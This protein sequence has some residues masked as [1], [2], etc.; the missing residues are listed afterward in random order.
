MLPR[1]STKL[2]SVRCGRCVQHDKTSYKIGPEIRL[3]KA[4]CVCKSP[5]INIHIEDNVFSLMSYRL[6]GGC[7][8]V[9]R[10]HQPSKQL[11]FFLFSSILLHNPLPNPTTQKK[12]TELL[13]NSAHSYTL[14]CQSLLQLKEWMETSFRLLSNT[15]VSCCSLMSLKSSRTLSFIKTRLFFFV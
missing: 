15:V 13:C 5:S 6:C 14:C 1:N 11:F 4:K 3:I 12:Q 8:V 9:T 7:S 2:F 10:R